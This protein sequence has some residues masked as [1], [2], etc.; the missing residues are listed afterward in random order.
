MIC[1]IKERRPATGRLLLHKYVTESPLADYLA[2]VADGLLVGRKH[3]PRALG[4]RLFQTHHHVLH[5]DHG[6]HLEVTAQDHRVEQFGLPHLRT[7][8]RGVDRIDF[9][10]LA[11]GVP[12]DA[13]RV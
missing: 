1:N 6:A 8:G 11:H 13:V 3:F 10:V 7:L 2:A 12:R 4:K 9:D 5:R